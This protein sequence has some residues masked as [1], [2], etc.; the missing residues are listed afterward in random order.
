MEKKNRI[1]PAL[2]AGLLLLALAVLLEHAV[3]MPEFL[4]GFLYGAAVALELLG[5]LFTAKP[6]LLKNT[7][8]RRLKLAL[9]AKLGNRG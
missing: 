3:G 2:A 4:D 5:A 1:H 6:G 9:V 8:F 7:A